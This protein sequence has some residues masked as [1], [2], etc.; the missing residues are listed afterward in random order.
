M[1][2]KLVNMD[3]YDIHRYLNSGLQDVNIQLNNGAYKLLS[4]I[5]VGDVLKDN[6]KVTGVVEILPD[7]KIKNITVSG[8]RLV[9]GP[10]IQIMDKYSGISFNLMDRNEN[11]YYTNHKLYHL[12]TDK[13][14]FFVNNV[15]IGD[16]SV[17]MNILFKE[18]LSQVLRR[19]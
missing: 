17:G 10:N 13:G 16:Y 9:G 12:I 2:D 3:T 15:Y 18:E 8:R 11:S 4:S 7:V 14:G 1:K 5:V 19:I 6:I